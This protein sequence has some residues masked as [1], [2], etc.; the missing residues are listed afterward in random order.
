MTRRLRI[1]HV[2]VQPV[3]VW[4]D[5]E[6]LEAGPEASAVQVKLSELAGM[7][8]QLRAEV[9]QAETQQPGPPAPHP[10]G[11]QIVDEYMDQAFQAA[12]RPR[13]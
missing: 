13:D 12:I 10:T 4:D 5:G 3:L 7:A 1:A 11:D 6:E 9:A 2:L 8:D